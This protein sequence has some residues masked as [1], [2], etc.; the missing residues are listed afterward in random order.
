MRIGIMSDTH[1]G[2]K[3]WQEVMGGVFSEVDFVLHSGDIFYHGVKNPLPE[4]YD[5]VGLAQAIAALTTP[6]LF[7]RGN[8]D[9]EVD[10]LV[11]DVPLQAPYI[12]CQFD[13]LRILMH[14]GHLWADEEVQRLSSRWKATVAVSGHTHV[15]R[16]ER[17]GKVVF[18]NPGSPALPKG[19]GI[20]TV[21]CIDL[22]AG[23][24][25][26]TVISLFDTRTQR[27]LKSLSIS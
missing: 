26:E 14:H 15:P 1:G 19:E 11:L 24:N 25:G 21:A 22:P 8:C 20:P 13:A 7:C 12:L 2:L 6:L 18:V 16:L 3:A 23:G 9:S 27:V 10:Q 5:T 17:E 4:G